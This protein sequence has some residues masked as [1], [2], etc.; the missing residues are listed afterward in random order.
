VA[1]LNTKPFSLARRQQ[2]IPTNTPTTFSGRAKV[3][4]CRRLV[5]DWQDL[6]DICGVPKHDRAKFE[7]GREAA[8]VWE[9]LEVREKL[10]FLPAFLEAI[11]RK[12]LI[13]ELI[14]SPC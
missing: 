2:A 7:R 5:D 8:R 12:D 4:I 3:A 9:W 14:D 13:G 10:A 1:L 11:G 6:A